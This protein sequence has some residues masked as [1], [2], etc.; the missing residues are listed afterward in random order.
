MY[1]RAAE[2]RHLI[3]ALQ[4]QFSLAVAAGDRAVMTE[5]D[6]GSRQFAREADA[7]RAQLKRTASQ[8]SGMLRDLEYGDES[9]LLDEFQGKF[10]AYEV[11][12]HNI[13]ELAVENTNLKATRLAFA[14]GKEEADAFKA[15]LST[16]TNAATGTEAW[17]IR[18]LALAA[19][20]AVGEI[21]VLEA[22]HIAE[23][24][25]AAMTRTEQ[26]MADSEAAARSSLTKL[27]D[28]IAREQLEPAR[29]AL[30]RFV[31]VNAEIVALSRRN[32]NVRS[33]AMTLGQ[34]RIII[35]TC[36]QSL[37]ALSEALTTRL[38]KPTR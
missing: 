18:A 28:L 26:Q 31:R 16:L 36:R 27:A 38:S 10:A 30:D 35:A 15:A 4:T 25:D 2:A 3:A 17:H 32:T 12:D 8:L 37:D 22:P 13:L 24:S 6:E 9:K 29:A 33:L 5:T 34:K 1:K 14:D 11:L 20:S 23:A 21:Q 19:A 7:A